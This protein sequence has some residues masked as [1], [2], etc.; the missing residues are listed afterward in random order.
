MSSVRRNVGA[1]LAGLLPIAEIEA[2]LERRQ[3]LLDAYRQ[4]DSP[5]QTEIVEFA[6]DLTELAADDAE[7]RRR[8]RVAVLHLTGRAYPPTDEDGDDT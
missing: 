6:Q 2:M 8:V 7:L 1:Y 5:T 4:G 3:A